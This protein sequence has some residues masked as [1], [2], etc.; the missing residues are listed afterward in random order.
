[1][2]P[3]ARR[4]HHAG[5][6]LDRV[7]L[8]LAA[9]EDLG[10][11]AAAEP[12]QQHPPRPREQ[13]RSTLGDVDVGLPGRSGRGVHDAVRPAVEQEVAQALVLDYADLP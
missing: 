8:P 12:E 5:V 1:M 3:P 7:H 13:L 10:G 2:E 9:R 11:A 6:D 4:L